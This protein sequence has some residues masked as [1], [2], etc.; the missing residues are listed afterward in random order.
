[1]KNIIYLSD[2]SIPLLR[3]GVHRCRLLINKIT[4]NY[5]ESR[6][7]TSKREA[8][9]LYMQGSLFFV[10]SVCTIPTF[11]GFYKKLGQIYKK[12]SHDK[13]GNN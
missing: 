2:F 5:L 12:L 8:V 13:F 9:L 7:L 1:M 3:R 11:S 10:I 4:S 6:F